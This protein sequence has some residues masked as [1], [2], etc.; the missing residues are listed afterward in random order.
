MESLQLDSC[1]ALEDLEI[2]KCKQL[3]ALES[4]QSLGT[5]RSL[6]LIGNSRL[7]SLQLH[8]CMLLEH[9]EIRV[10]WSLVTLEGLRSLVH[11]KRLKIQGRL[12]LDAL[13]TVESRELIVGI[14]S[15]SF[16]L[17]PELE[18]LEL[19]SLDARRL[20]HEQESALLLLRSLQELQFRESR[21]LEDLPS[22]LCSLPSL[23]RLEIQH[24]NSISGLP[25]EGLPPSLEELVINSCSDKLSE[26]C[27]SLAT[28]K[29]EVKI[30]WRYVD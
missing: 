5:L 4:M 6:V 25:K 12:A 3:V 24:C 7:E 1:T 14:S 19:I 22:G 27:R 16:E 11:L 29:L 2:N 9:L 13:T 15:H 28:S 10:C 30:D 17:F 20:T 18:S 21:H 8:S 23:K 26:A